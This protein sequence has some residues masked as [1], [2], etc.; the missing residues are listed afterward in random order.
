MI[1]SE[2]DD[3]KQSYYV[4]TG[5]NGNPE[6]MIVVSFFLNYLY[7]KLNIT[8]MHR[9]QGTVIS[10]NNFWCINTAVN[11]CNTWLLNSVLVLWTEVNSWSVLGLRNEKKKKKRQQ[12]QPKTK[13]NTHSTYQMYCWHCYCNCRNNNV[14][15]VSTEFLQKQYQC[16]GQCNSGQIVG[17]FFFKFKGVIMVIIEFNMVWV[18]LD[19]FVNICMDSCCI[20]HYFQVSLHV[21]AYLYIIL[22]HFV[23]C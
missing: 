15:I 2:E 10:V 3:F 18:R 5:N 19:I 21:H 17:S 9:K 22:L 16:A 7:F 23:F 1:T 11:F 4:W 20:A 14:V 8:M 13:Q 12:Q 6:K